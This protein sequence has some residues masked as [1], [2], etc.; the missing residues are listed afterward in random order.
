V[1]N[2]CKEDD[3]GLFAPICVS[4]ELT[5]ILKTVSS[6]ERKDIDNVRQI[7]LVSNEVREGFFNFNF[8]MRI[9]YLVF[10]FS[11]KAVGLSVLF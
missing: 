10:F 11:P 9:Y 4:H 2:S 1:E 6:A 3:I 5:F 7:S 8:L